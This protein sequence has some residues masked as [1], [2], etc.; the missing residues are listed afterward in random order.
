MICVDLVERQVDAVV[1][2]PALRKVVGADALAE[3]SPLP[4]SDL[5][6]AAC[7][8]C[9]SLHLL[10]VDA[11]GQHGHRLRL[12]LVLRAIVLALDHDAGR[13]V[14]D[15]H[16]GIG[17]VDVLAAGAG[18]AEGIDAQFG[19]VQHDVRDLVGLGQHGDRARGSV[20]ASLRFGRRHALHAMAAGFE[21]ELGVGALCRR[22]GDDFLVAAELGRD[23]AT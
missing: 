8:L 22:S 18:R 3:R 17:L 21:L 6:V 5:R 16:R 12:V 2:D 11:R 15:A 19:R 10:V 7:L 13:Q 9:C 20:D 1:G 14:R 23:F 4:I